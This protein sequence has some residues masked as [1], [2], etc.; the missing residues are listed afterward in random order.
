MFNI[1]YVRKGKEIIPTGWSA[2]DDDKDYPLIDTRE[3][4]KSDVAD[5]VDN[6]SD[7]ESRTRRSSESSDEE[8]VQYD[9]APTRMNEE[10]DASDDDLPPP[11]VQRVCFISISSPLL[12]HKLSS[13]FHIFLQSR[14][15]LTED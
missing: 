6:E 1:A 10:F 5:A 3:P 8:D 9:G 4:Q 7:V 13:Q 15:I 2:I 14:H 12:T 11:I